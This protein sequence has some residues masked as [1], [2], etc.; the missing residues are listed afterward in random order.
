[1]PSVE[2]EQIAIPDGSTVALQ[3]GGEAVRQPVVGIPRLVHRKG[4]GL[5]RA[6][7]AHQAVMFDVVDGF[8]L[9]D[10]IGRLR[11]PEHQRDGAQ[12]RGDRQQQRGLHR[13]GPSQ[14]AAPQ[15]ALELAPLLCVQPPG[16]GPATFQ[17]TRQELPQRFTAPRTRGVVV[18][19]RARVVATVM[20][21]H[22]VAVVH[23]GHQHPGQQTVN[24]RA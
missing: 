1:M 22:E 18:C 9:E 5:A 3:I 20:L 7:A 14:R 23:A 15:A 21:D 10:G 11:Q 12:Q 24:A 16:A 8:E 13:G 17:S 19:G 2:V 4:L 6:H